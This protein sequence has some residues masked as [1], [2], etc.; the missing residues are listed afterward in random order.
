MTFA[1]KKELF[2]L[3]LPDTGEDK[4]SGLAWAMFF[5]T[6]IPGS[7][8]VGFIAYHFLGRLQQGHVEEQIWFSLALLLAAIPIAVL[9]VLVASSLAKKQFGLNVVGTFW[10]SLLWRYAVSTSIYN[11]VI[12]LVNLFLTIAPGLLM[13]VANLGLFSL[14]I[15]YMVFLLPLEYFVH[16][17]ILPRVFW[18]SA[19]ETP[20]EELSGF[21]EDDPFGKVFSS[22]LAS[23]LQG[24]SSPSYEVINKYDQSD[25][26]SEERSQENP[27]KT[28][29]HYDSE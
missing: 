8:I 9:K 16:K 17:Y 27:T 14:F 20:N 15:I 12:A 22:E 7:I 19:R 3:S 21:D 18:L 13:M 25:K 4:R 2:L 29:D 26:S 23:R 5:F 1:Q 11:L 6:T 24:G 10:W 28:A